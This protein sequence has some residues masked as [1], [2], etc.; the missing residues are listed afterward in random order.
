MFRLA[1]ALSIRVLFVLTL[2]VA[3]TY[4]PPV[5]AQLSSDR[6]ADHFDRAMEHVQQRE[7]EQ[8]VKEFQRAYELEPNHAVLYNLA[9]VYSAMQRPID[10]IRTL[11]ECLSIGGSEL[12]PARVA[13]VRQLIE[14][15]KQKLALLQI[16][17]QPE[18]AEILIDGEAVEPLPDGRVPVAPGERDLLLRAPDHAPWSRQLIAKAGH[19]VT[20]EVTLEL[21]EAAPSGPSL[22]VRCPVH[23]VD[24][25]A[26]GELVGTLKGGAGFEPVAVPAG[27]RVLRFE[28][29]DYTG[30]AIAI[31]SL[32]EGEVIDCQLMRMPEPPRETDTP[33][34]G[35][36]PTVRHDWAVA[37][38]GAGVSFG[39]SAG[40]IW[41]YNGERAEEWKRRSSGLCQSGS[42]VVPCDDP[43][44]PLNSTERGTLELRDSI[45]RWDAISQGLAVAG[46]L[47]VSGAL[48]LYFWPEASR[49]TGSSSG[50]WVSITATSI[51]WQG[52]F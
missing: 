4:A 30:P 5:L 42:K 3:G 44:R 49:K 17:A 6:A 24:V 1:R 2:L 20:L 16:R 32:P 37:L 45:Q 47:A 43:G 18:T 29:P 48:A 14:E 21:A 13:R 38:A 52:V 22:R 36:Q 31:K 25:I 34:N 28:H 27:S 40:L 51:Q 46:T 9:Q 50:G 11:H 39:F 8:A 23:E 10:A 15:Q 7:Y 19:E 35:S 26:D 12:K 33:H 41:M